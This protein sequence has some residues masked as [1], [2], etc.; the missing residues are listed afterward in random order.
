MEKNE[1]DPLLYLKSVEA[2]LGEV[3]A[4]VSHSWHDDC[5]LKWE[6]L[7]AYREEFKRANN[8]REPLV[9]I[10]KCCL[11]QHDIKEGLM[12]LPVFL[13]GCESLLVLAG[14]TYPQRLWCVMELFIFLVM[15]GAEESV[16][17]RILDVSGTDGAREGLKSF[18]VRSGS[19]SVQEDQD[20]MLTAIAGAFGSLD[21]FSGEVRLIFDHL[22]RAQESK[23]GLKKSKSVRVRNS[24]Q[25]DKQE[26]AVE[27]ARIVELERKIRELEEGK[28]KTGNGD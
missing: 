2:S 24:I 12:C 8:G 21:K 10:D 18:D 20:R 15:G 3:D 4:F 27:R 14:N 22:L 26:R 25:E 11:N 28:G 7:Q 17:L 1:P 6:Q 23:N 9:W 19:C 16:D 13:A 5:D